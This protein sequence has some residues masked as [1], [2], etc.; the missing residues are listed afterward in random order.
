MMR[1][2]EKPAAEIRDIRAR[3]RVRLFSVAAAVLAVFGTVLLSTWQLEPRYGAKTLTEWAMQYSANYGQ[4]GTAKEEATTAIRAIG[5]NGIP[6]MLG[7][8]RSKDSNF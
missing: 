6:V 3:S 5:T 1:P 2:S 4:Y 8:V 7:L